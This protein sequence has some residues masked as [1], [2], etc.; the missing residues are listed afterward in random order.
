[1]VVLNNPSDRDDL[2]AIL[3]TQI[4]K[5]LNLLLKGNAPFLPKPM[6]LTSILKTQECQV[7]RMVLFTAAN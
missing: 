2:I 5:N 3:C 1:M 7:G 4:P 6:Q